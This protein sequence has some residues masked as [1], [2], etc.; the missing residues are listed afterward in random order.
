METFY[1]LFRFLNWFSA[2]HPHPVFAM[3]WW[4]QIPWSSFPECWVLSQHFHSPLSLSSRD[5]LVLHFSAIRVVLSAYLRLLMFLPAVLIPACVS[6]SPA[7]LVMYSAYKLNKQG[8]NI[9]PWRTAFPIWNQSV[10]P[11]SVLTVGSWPAYSFLTRQV[12]WSDIPTS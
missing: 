3:K 12:R 2:H 6:S 10:G 1:H 8:D 5:S 4:D 11:C 9:Q 7:F